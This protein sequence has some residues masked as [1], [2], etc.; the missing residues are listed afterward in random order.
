MINLSDWF[1]S[2]LSLF[3]KIWWIILPLILFFIFWDLLHDY[4]KRKFIK[5]IEWK[6]L[7]VRVPRNIEKT[8]KTM[9]Q[10]FA[11]FH[12]IMLPDKAKWHQK[13]FK[14]IV[15]EWLSLE[16]VGFKGSVYFFVRT[17]EKF[18]NIVEAQIYAQ[19]PD[20]EI[21]EAADFFD[22]LPASLPNKEFDIWGA[23]IIL[24]KEDPYPIR[25]YPAFEESQ[26]EKR[27]DP[28]SVITETMAKL[29]KDEII[30]LQFLI[31]PVGD[32]WK[33]KAQDLINKLAGRNQKKKTHWLDEAVIFIKNLIIAPFEHPVWPD[34]KR[35]ET[36]ESVFLTTGEKEAIEAIENKLA[37]LGF[38]AGIRFLYCD[39]AG[40]FTRSNIATVMSVFRQFNTQNLNSL[41]PNKYAMT[42]TN[43]LKPLFKARR[44]YIIK[45]EF[46]QKCKNR[47][48][49]K[50]ATVFNIEELATIFHFPTIM[51]ESPTLRMVEAKKG[52]PPAGLPIG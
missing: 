3:L 9:E 33:I 5:A 41:K 43:F 30:W 49:L 27:V 39:K 17:P 36:K 50:K 4:T 1:F 13:A 34:E 25:T 42:K 11:G 32:D 7:E 2:I 37:K 48:F 31:R 38:E 35:S 8:I 47:G 46:F 19:Y 45:E 40:A 24:A 21:K 10:V 28:L 52:E 15:Q 14:G 20:A 12:G 18:R 16:I 6:L 51:V 22:Y 44:E 26:E 29:N 23:E